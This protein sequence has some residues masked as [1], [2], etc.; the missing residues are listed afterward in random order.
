MPRCFGAHHRGV[1]VA[2][3]PFRGRVLGCAYGNADTGSGEELAPANSQRR[4]QRGENAFGTCRSRR[5]IADI[6]QQDAELIGTQTCD[7]IAGCNAAGQSSANR[8]EQPVA[9]GVA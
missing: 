8:L 9:R 3:Q 6:F 7:R 4:P 5:R 2:Q 1:G